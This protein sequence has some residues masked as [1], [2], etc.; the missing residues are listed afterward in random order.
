M[1][2]AQVLV[3]GLLTGIISMIA[4]GRAIQILGAG[5]ATL[6]PALG[7]GSAVLIGIP[8]VGELPTGLQ[9]GGLLVVTL[10]LIFSLSAGRRR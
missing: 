7:P 2:V 5:R 1:L 8:V 6:F 9:I 3:Q 10:G 4:F